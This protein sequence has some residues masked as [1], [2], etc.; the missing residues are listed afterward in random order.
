MLVLA[1]G[2][3]LFP[4]AQ[5]KAD[6]IVNGDFEQGNTAFSS[7]YF[8][9][10][11]NITPT[12]TYDIVTNPALSRPGATAPV[13][14]GDHTSGTGLMM[15]VNGAITPDVLVWGQIVAVKPNSPY[16]FAAFISSWTAA[17]P[18][19]LDV[20]FNGTSI[21]IM[22]APSITAFWSPFSASWNSGSAT[23]VVIE[24]RSLST[25]GFGNDFA[26]DDLALKGPDTLAV[27]EPASVVLSL[28]GSLALVLGAGVRRY[29]RRRG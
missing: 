2:L 18:G 1:L 25:S 3:S 4:A 19:Q 11:G 6:L 24:L 15:A 23:S 10:P 16:T 26:L 22:N 17:A 5:A 20:V 8:F 13:A 14:Y 28:T 21:G 29:R 7:N 27:P 9:S 12:R